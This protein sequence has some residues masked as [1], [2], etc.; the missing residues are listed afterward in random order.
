MINTWQI[1]TRKKENMP[2][3]FRPPGG[4]VGGG[5][6]V[7]AAALVPPLN[8]LVFIAPVAESLDSAFECIGDQLPSMF[9]SEL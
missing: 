1:K 6:G 4:V 9:A 5:A 7:A 8:W 3:T 2:S